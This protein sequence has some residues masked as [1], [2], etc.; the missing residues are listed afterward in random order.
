ML[1]LRP[2]DGRSADDER[3][4]DAAFREPSLV[5]TE[6]RHRHLRPH[7]AVGDA[8]ARIAPRV[9][10][11]LRPMDR[12]EEVVTRSRR[13]RDHFEEVSS[14]GAVVAEHDED[15]VLVLADLLEVVYEPADVEVEVLHH[16]GVELHLLAENGPARRCQHDGIRNKPHS[17]GEL[18]ARGHC[19]LHPVVLASS[20]WSITAVE[21]PDGRA[22]RGLPGLPRNVVALGVVSLLTDV[23]TE[24]IVPVLPLFVVSVLGASPAGLGV[25][26]GVAES[27]AALMRLGSGW[28]SDRIGQAQAVP[29]LRLRHLGRGQ[30]RAGAGALVADGAGAALRRPRRQGPAQPAAR[31]AHRRLGRAAPP[32]A[33]L[34][35]PPRAR[36]AGRGHRAAGGLRAAERLPGR[37]PAHLPALGGAGRRS[38]SWCSRRSCGRAAARRRP[39]ARRSSPQARGMGGAVPPL[40]ASRPGSSRSPTRAPP[41]CC[42]WPRTARTARASRARSVTLV[43]LL[44][45]LVYAALSWPVGEL[46]DRIGRRPHPARG[47]PALRRPLR[48][49]GVARGR[50]HDRG[51]LRPAGG[52]QR[53]ARGLAAQHAG[54]PGG[55]RRSAARPT[56][57]TTPWWARRCCPPASS[58]GVLWERLG[59][60]ATLAV[61]AAARAAGG[62][63]SSR[64]CC[65]RAA[66]TVT[67]MATLRELGEFEVIRRLTA[68]RGAE[69][70]GAA[71]AGVVV[72]SGD[73]AAVLRPGAGHGPGGHDRRLR[74]GRALPAGVVSRRGRARGAA[75]AR[76]PERPGGDGRHAAL[77]A[78]LDRGAAR[79]RGRGPG[80]VPVGARGRAA[81]GGRGAG[82]GEPHRGGRAPS[83]TR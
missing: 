28:L 6:G 38:R 78:A 49:A 47:L 77:G 75:G 66:S 82:G 14:L 69:P 20:P 56:G 37:L 16:A 43:Y 64:C 80:G 19:P 79:E 7:R 12:R 54:R 73:D 23:S 24:M 17:L 21:S 63:C 45:N 25:I 61:D 76:E 39:R 65:R 55:A 81:R 13:A 8:R 74:G 26:E 44:Y 30:G 35:L 27:T 10:M 9:G 1:P 71:A 33:R 67:A 68:A 31:R 58:P 70:A 34:R 83:G 42:C 22:R 52:A 3:V 62:G 29:A 4:P 5:L 18:R 11:G 51:R 41:S 15:G 50:R 53:A 57:S 40:P 36:H 48:P 72:D 60:R 2:L 59:P 46:S 32:R